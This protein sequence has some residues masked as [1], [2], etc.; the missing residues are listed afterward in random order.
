[1]ECK[2]CHNLDFIIDDDY[3]MCCKCYLYYDVHNPKV[4]DDFEIGIITKEYKNAD[5]CIKC[6]DDNVKLFGEQYICYSCGC[7]NGYR[8]D[9]YK[10]IKYYHLHQLL[11]ITTS[12][13]FYYKIINR[14]LDFN[15]KRKRIYKFDLILKNNFKI[16]DYKIK[17]NVKE[18]KSFNEVFKSLDL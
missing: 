17:I 11:L 4:I 7:C 1:M 16:L 3:L 14:L 13:M 10:K 9:D 2:L 6:S 8:F 15:L 18:N 12:H 5:L